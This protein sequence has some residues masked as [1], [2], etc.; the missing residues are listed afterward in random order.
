MVESESVYNIYTKVANLW[1]V[2][3]ISRYVQELTAALRRNIAQ[4]H[5][6]MFC[7]GYSYTMFS[8]LSVTVTLIAESAESSP[9]QRINYR[10]YI[11][12]GDPTAP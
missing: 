9:M 2:W 5:T 1:N 12:T 10:I 7:R 11:S 8:S 3:L 6:A 4:T